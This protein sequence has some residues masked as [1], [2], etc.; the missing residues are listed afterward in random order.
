MTGIRAFFRCERSVLLKVC[1]CKRCLARRV[2]RNKVAARLHR[3][4]E[5]VETEN[6][7]KRSHQKLLIKRYQHYICLS[8]QTL[9]LFYF[10]QPMS[11][12]VPRIP[13][14]KNQSGTRRPMKKSKYFLSLLMSIIFLT[15]SGMP[16]FAAGE[17][18]PTFNGTGKVILQPA[19]RLARI[20]DIAVQADGK[21]IAAGDIYIPGQ[22]VFLD[23]MVI[24]INADG[25]LDNTFGTNGMKFVDFLGDDDNG[26]SVAIQPDGKI[27]MAG[28]AYPEVGANFAVMRL[29]TDGSLDTSFDGDGKALTNLGLEAYGRSVAIQYDGKIVVAGLAYVNEPNFGVVRYLENGALDNTFGDGG[30]VITE[31]LP[32]MDD[33]ANAIAVQ[34]DGKIL[35]GGQSALFDP[36]SGSLSGGKKRR[37][38]LGRDLGTE[39]GMAAAIESLFALARYDANGKLDD[40]FG[41]DGKALTSISAFRDVINDLAVKED[42]KI[43]AV[44]QA[45]NGTCICLGVTQ[46]TPDGQLD[47][48]FGAGGIQWLS[49]ATFGNGVALQPDD[50]I[51][52]ATSRGSDFAAS[53]LREFGLQDTTFGTPGLGIAILDI[54]DRDTATSVAMQTDGKVV[55]GGILESGPPITYRVGVARLMGDSPIP[56]TARINGQVQDSEGHSVPNSRVELKNLTTGETRIISANPFGYFRTGDLPTNNVFRLTAQSKRR[57]FPAPQTIRLLGNVNGLVI[58]SQ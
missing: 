43:V 44:G 40:T 25:S 35:V 16:V 41:N 7:I 13:S 55:L 57:V 1:L 18:D 29:N 49:Q 21:I 31:I 47:G 30:K 54:F 48:T 12:I 14:G 4:D 52:T 50:K 32:G 6:D 5:Q 34:N 38:G 39:M 45:L 3:K 2:S 46:Y 28:Y 26:L 8:L 20:N 23:F 36:F 15:F 58:P 11:F 33:R 24:R 53:R 51:L 42:G 37:P 22:T 27:V 9:N 19:P 56:S 17:P 10:N